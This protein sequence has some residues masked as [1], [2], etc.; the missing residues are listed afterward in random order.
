MDRA[1]GEE[2]ACVELTGFRRDLLLSILPLVHIALIPRS[3]RGIGRRSLFSADDRFLLFLYVVVNCVSMKVASTVFGVSK[4]ICSRV[5]LETA[6]VL[7][8][9]AMLRLHD[10]FDNYMANPR[11]FYIC[12]KQRNYLHI[13]SEIS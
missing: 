13:N 12:Y 7:S 8:A 1:L 5:F 6:V 9:R 2:T 3:A 11:T 4:Q 10:A